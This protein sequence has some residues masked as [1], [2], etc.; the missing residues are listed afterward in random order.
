M[1]KLQDL[2][3]QD[4]LEDQDLIEGIR[5]SL[6]FINEDLGE[7]INDVHTLLGRG[8]ITYAYLWALFPP[9][10]YIHGYDSAT[11]QHFVAFAKALSYE[12]SQDE[13][14]FVQLQCDIIAHDDDGIGLA[15]CMFKIPQFSGAYSILELPVCP[16]EFYP[17]REALRKKAISRGKVYANTR[18]HF[19]EHQGTATLCVGNGEGLKLS[20]GFVHIVVSRS[21]ADLPYLQVKERIMV[22]VESFFE[23]QYRSK[24]AH[25]VYRRLNPAELSED[26]LMICTPVLLGFCFNT[27][28]WG[29]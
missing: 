17:G 9:N 29:A 14:N 18:M 28:A 16:L 3:A 12:R 15:E 5:A 26:E 21:C 7:T 10:T 19:Y 11:D 20:V 23:F 1:A 25:R 24:L 13:G 22:D 8:Q 27:K 6:R 2:E 4:R